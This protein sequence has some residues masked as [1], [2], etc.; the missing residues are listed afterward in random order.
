M[1]LDDIAQGRIIFNA[2]SYLGEGRKARA[3]WELAKNIFNLES[4]ARGALLHQVKKRETMLGGMFENPTN[5]SGLMK[6]IA[7]G[8]NLGLAIK[9]NSWD[10]SKALDPD[11][12]FYVNNDTTPDESV[13]K[14][15]LPEE[16]YAK[17]DILPIKGFDKRDVPEYRSESIKDYEFLIRIPHNQLSGTSEIEILANKTFGSSQNGFGINFSVM[18]TNIEL[19]SSNRDFKAFRENLAASVYNS[20]LVFRNMVQKG[21]IVDTAFAR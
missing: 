12:L 9:N 3:Y 4:Y 16:V 2:A 21:Y 11:L 8:Y 19:S 18:P 20:N 6:D 5:Y 17:A 7:L 10:I 1:A 15:T 13:L 14:L